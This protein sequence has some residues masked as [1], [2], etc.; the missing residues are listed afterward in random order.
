[1]VKGIGPKGGSHL[2]QKFGTLEG[3][4]AGRESVS[5]MQIRGAKGLQALLR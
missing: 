2:L 4:F 1:G 5:T 3:V